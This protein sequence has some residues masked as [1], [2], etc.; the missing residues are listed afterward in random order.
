MASKEAFA[1]IIL[2]DVDRLIDARRDDAAVVVIVGRDA[3]VGETG[4]DDPWDALDPIDDHFR[5]WI[6]LGPPHLVDLQDVVPLVPRIDR[7]GVDCLAVNYGCADDQPDRNGELEHD[8]R[9]AQPA[10]ARGFRCG[11]VGLEDLSRLEP[12]QEKGWVQAAG[13][14]DQEGQQNCRKQD[15]LLAEI[16]ERKIGIEECREWLHQ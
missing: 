13:H 4:R 16:T 10:R 15:P 9:G 3:N 11:S 8:Q 5:H 6:E 1:D 12:G 14:A 7:T 2:P